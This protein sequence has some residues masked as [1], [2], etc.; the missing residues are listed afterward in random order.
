MN[1][2][3]KIELRAIEQT[4]TVSSCN[5]CTDTD[6]TECTLYTDRQTA[7]DNGYMDY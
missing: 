5:A 4:Q 6:C 7:I 1:R 3:L 2:A